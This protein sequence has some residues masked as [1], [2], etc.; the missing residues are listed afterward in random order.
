MT[1]QRI[2]DGLMLLVLELAS[3]SKTYSVSDQPDGWEPHEWA[4]VKGLASGETLRLARLAA[5]E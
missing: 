5:A 4:Y 3:P 1:R 2:A